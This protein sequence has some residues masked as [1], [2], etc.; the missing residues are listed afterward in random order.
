MTQDTLLTADEPM[1]FDLYQSLAHRTANYIHPY[2]PIAGLQEEAA[3]VANLFMKQM[4]RG[5]KERPD[6]T[7][8][9]IIGELG[10][11]LWMLSEIA[12][13]NH[14]TLHEIA[15][16]NIRKLAGRAER[17]SIYGDGEER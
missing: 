11:T 9:Q 14:I 4:L 12:T 1:G 17:K 6:P 7:R 15:D 5:D 8:E 3:E 13:Q 10:D 2:Y 16:Y